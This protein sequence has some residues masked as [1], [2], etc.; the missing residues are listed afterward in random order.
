MAALSFPNQSH[1]EFVLKRITSFLDNN[2]SL[3]AKHEFGRDVKNRLVTFNSAGKMVRGSLLLSVYEL[4]TGKISEE[5]I[6][7]AAALELVHG[8]LLIHDDIMDNDHLRRGED[9]I[10]AQYI[11][12]GTEDFGKSMGICVGDIGFFLAYQLLSTTKVGLRIKDAIISLFSTELQSV[13]LAQMQDVANGYLQEE[14]KE[15]QIINVYLYKT[16]RYTFS[17]PMMLGALLAGKESISLDL[18]KLGQDLGVLFQMKDDELGLFA[19]TEA[20]GK[21]V[22]TD[23]RENKKT[24]YRQY[25]FSEA[26][27]PEREKLREIFGNPKSS[28]NDITYVYD[29]LSKYVIAQ[30]IDA[31]IAKYKKSIEKKITQLSIEKEQKEFFSDILRYSLEREK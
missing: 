31:M 18:E 19:T 28:T 20:I 12:F 14:I 15:D 27:E 11:H 22:G 2:D 9:S 24:L 30:K 16:G 10:Y 7:V 13:T 6:M 23:I 26:T 25:L 4:F 3:F 8:S 29:L 5:A 17:L 21:P 1:K